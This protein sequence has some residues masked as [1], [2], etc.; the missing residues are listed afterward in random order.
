VDTHLTV[1]AYLITDGGATASPDGIVRK[2]ALLRVE[3]GPE[4]NNATS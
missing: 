2:A 1:V 3:L 4:P